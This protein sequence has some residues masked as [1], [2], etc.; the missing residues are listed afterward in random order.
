MVVLSP[1]ALTVIGFAKISVPLGNLTLHVS[2]A[3]SV[4]VPSN[5]LFSPINPATNEFS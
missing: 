4:T 3:I 5:I 2:P 1:L